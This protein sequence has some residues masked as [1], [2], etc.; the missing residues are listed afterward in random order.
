LDYPIAGSSGEITALTKRILQELCDVAP[1]EALDIKY[2][3]K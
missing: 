1:T 2:G 3:D